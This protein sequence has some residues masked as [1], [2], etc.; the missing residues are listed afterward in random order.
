MSLLPVPMPTVWTMAPAEQWISAEQVMDATG[1]SRATFFRRSSELLSR[2]A[3]QSAANGKPI[4]EYLASSLPPEARAK[5]GGEQPLNVVLADP[6]QAVLRTQP[7][8][9][10]VRVALTHPEDEAQAAERYA[11]LEPILKFEDDR[12][13]RLQARTIALTDGKPVTSCTRLIAY[14][15]M[16]H[17]LSVRTVKRWLR[18]FREGGYPALA[19]KERNDRHV[20]RW[21]RERINAAYLAAYL[22]L[23]C[24]QSYR[25]VYEAIL[26]D[27]ELLQIPDSDLPSY[28]TVRAWLKGLPPYLITYARE[29]RRAYQERMAP[30]V[31]RRYTDVAANQVWVS[32]HMIHDVE[33]MNDCFPEAPMGAPIRLRFTCLLDYRARYVVGTSWSWEGSSRSIATAV[34][35]AVLQYGAAEHFYCDNGKDYRRVAKGA[36]PAYLDESPLA[37]SNWFGDEVRWM[38]GMG[39]LGR[40]RMKVTHC[41]VRHPQS[42]H[43]ER[44]F[45]TLHER[46]DKRW[47]TY[48]AGASHLRPDATAAAMELHRKLQRHGRVSE[49]CHPTASQFIQSCLAWIDE[50]HRRPHSG[51]GMGGASPLD[52]FEQERR[53][54]SPEPIDPQALVLLLSEQTRRKVRECSIELNKRRY[55]Y[56]DDVSRDVLHELNEREVTVAYD[57]N[58]SEAVAVLD[59]AGHLVCW[60]RAEAVLQF[61]PQDEGTQ[62]QIAASMADRRHIEKAT[63]NLVT[64]IARTARRNGARH[65]V[66]MIEGK[67]ASSKSVDAVLT[68]RARTMRPDITAQAPLS[69]SEI[70][71][72]ILEE[73]RCLKQQRS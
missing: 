24:R 59:D 3:Q 42:K 6:E 43:V 16:R 32:D 19:D 69:A 35:H 33:V 40:L 11:I 52:V 21:F 47:P 53:A 72:N 5:L 9:D 1:W 14:Q 49:S 13:L 62:Q 64:G 31:R 12:A 34:R 63:R 48:T 23:D 61:A 7:Q 4:R 58:D 17:G 36:M 51:E 57:P 50:Y 65:P 67:I 2:E 27:R 29:G 28:E 38:E 37:K 15:A 10:K 46:F 8:P 18:R 68:H 20:S 30:Y 56:Y 70:A 39:I 55:T 22:F 41:I 44:F 66:E 73:M 60:A 54:A 26:E 25:V 71:A 45:R